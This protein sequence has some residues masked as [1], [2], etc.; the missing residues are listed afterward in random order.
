M[1]LAPLGKVGGAWGSGRGK[2]APLKSDFF[3][4]FAVPH[5]KWVSS[6]TRDPTGV[7]CIGRLEVCSLNHQTTRQILGAKLNSGRRAGPEE[8]G[9]GPDLQGSLPLGAALFA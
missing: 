3:F 2:L 4:F 8:P 7:P 5:S 1:S 6:L 9:C